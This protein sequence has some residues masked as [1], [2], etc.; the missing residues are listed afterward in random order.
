[1][2]YESFSWLSEQARE[3]KFTHNKIYEKTF[4]FVVVSRSASQLEDVLALHECVMSSRKS[5]NSEYFR[6]K[7]RH[8]VFLKRY[9]RAW[10]TFATNS[11]GELEYVDIFEQT[12]KASQCY[13]SVW[14]CGWFMPLILS[15][16]QQ[17]LVRLR[18]VKLFRLLP[19]HIWW[20][21]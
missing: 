1:M 4:S 20:S 16:A 15:R 5:V 21:C 7:W 3:K 13:F 9:S 11:M 14:V 10:F 19:L 12:H 6:W 2:I 8:D 18:L 17:R